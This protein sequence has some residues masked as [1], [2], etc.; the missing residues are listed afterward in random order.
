[1]VPIGVR[2]GPE[3]YLVAPVEPAG[4]V[5]VVQLEVAEELSSCVVEVFFGEPLFAIV[6]CLYT[7]LSAQKRKGKR[8]TLFDRLP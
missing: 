5:T 8:M 1:M 7:L 2:G 3:L 4:L 6:S